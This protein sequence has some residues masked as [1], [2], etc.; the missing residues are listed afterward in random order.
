MAAKKDYYEVLGVKKTAT[1]DEIKKAYRNLAKKWHP[2]KNKGNKDAEN[3]FK[4][5]SEAYAVLSDKEKRE[6]YDR[7]GKEAFSYGGPGG[8][9]FD[10][11][12]FMRA[13]RSGG[14]RSSGGRGRTMD[15][16]DIFGDLFG[17]GGSVEY[18]T[19]PQRGH[20]VEA[21][22]TIP[23][24]DALLGT[25]LDLQFSD[26]NTVKVKIPEGV[27]DGQR[28]RIRGKGA[29]GYNGGPPGDLHLLVHVQPHPFFERRGDD[30][31]TEIPITFGE[32]IR[33]AEIEVPTINGPVRAKI[34]P[35]TQGGQTFRLRGKG[36]KKKTSTGDH[37]YKVHIAVP[38][39]V[40]EDALPAVEKIESLYP[41]NPRANLKVAL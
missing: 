27:A 41:E 30:I 24:R 20:D 26:G 35:G 21:E 38:K 12:E 11:S 25:T 1:E 17:G 15:F 3:K 32:A 7:V 31:Y 33:G 37:Y 5:M 29:P 4:E 18:E 16:T 6:Q 8:G 2:D 40:P 9:G 39:S 34:P 23:F 10:F 36:V 22:T 14:G 19:G 28:L 13:A